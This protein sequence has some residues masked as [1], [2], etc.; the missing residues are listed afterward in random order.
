MKEQNQR[1]GRKDKKDVS[2][3]KSMCVISVKCSLCGLGQKGLAL[4]LSK[5]NNWLGP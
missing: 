4:C 2:R 5:L 3:I 1:V